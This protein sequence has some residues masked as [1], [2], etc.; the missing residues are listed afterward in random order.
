MDLK[1]VKILVKEKWMKVKNSALFYG[2]CACVGVVIC[3]SA[4]ALHDSKRIKKLEDRLAENVRV[5]NDNVDKVNDFI[6]DTEDQIN[7]L[8]RQN[9]ELMERAL[10][11]TEGKAS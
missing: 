6:H 9:N 8:V 4:T 2:L 7:V 1:K 5:H 11:V 10:H 3:G